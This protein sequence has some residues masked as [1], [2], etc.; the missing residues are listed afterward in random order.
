MRIKTF[1]ALLAL[2]LLAA[3]LSAFAL[4]SAAVTKEARSFIHTLAAGHYAASEKLFDKKMQ[5]AAP[6]KKLATVWHAI[7]GKYGRL[8]VLGQSKVMPYKQYTFVFVKSTF[9]KAA[10]V[11]KVVFNHSGKIA[12]F[13]ILP[14]TEQP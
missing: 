5:H 13:F 12:G 1:P 9:S 2:L 14:Q 4:S 8:K 3:P 10:A 6:P 11:L 7:T